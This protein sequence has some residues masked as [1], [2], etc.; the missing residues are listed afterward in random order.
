MAEKRTTTAHNRKIISGSTPT[1]AD[2]C[3]IEKS[4]NRSDQRYNHVPCPH[5][6]HFHVLEWTNLHWEKG[7]PYT[8]H[9]VCHSL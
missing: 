4:F 5:C 7:Q 8:A 2:A 3:R 9:F 1:I 6:G